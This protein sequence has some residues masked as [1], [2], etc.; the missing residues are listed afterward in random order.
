MSLFSFQKSTQRIGA[1]IDIGSGSVLTAVV[2]SKPGDLAPTIIWSNREHAP[3]KDIDSL[4][5]SAKSIMT[6]LVNALLKFDV[7]GRRALYEFDKHASI[8]E[9]QCCISAPWAYTVTK[10]IEYAEDSPFEVTKTLFDE[11]I[12][13]ALKKTQV[14]LNEN[15][16]VNELGLTVITRSTVDILTNGYRIKNPIGEQASTLALSHVSVVTQKYLT[17]HID[18]LRHKLFANTPIHKLSYILAL[19]SVTQELAPDQQEI[20]L[21]DITYE[22][23][24]IGIVRDGTLTYSTHTPFGAFSLAREIST[25]TSVPLYEAFQ[26]LHSAEPL[27][28][29]ASL[30]AKQQEEINAVLEAYIQK[31]SDLFHE[32]GDDLSI[33]RKIYI[34]TNLQSEPFF[35]DIIRTA[36]TRALKSAPDVKPITPLIVD[37]V[38][39]V[40]G[41]QNSDTAMLVSAMFFHTQN[42]RRTFEYL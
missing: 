8:S 15:E 34:H 21:V 16:A 32:T 4:D 12:E 9:I 25:I 35:A 40:A 5:Q 29:K 24:E 13:T 41:N 27:S 22:A 37:R 11:L 17:D 36:G 18:E 38:N 39:R 3:L 26:Y 30:P 1:I 2:A 6:A 28:F 10:T 31:V 42:T 7:D 23:T 19:Y 33:P 20:C 14:E